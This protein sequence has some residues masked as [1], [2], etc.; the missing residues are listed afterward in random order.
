MR[1]LSLDRSKAMDERERIDKHR[2]TPEQMLAR[3]R[4]DERRQRGRLRVFLGAAPGVGKTYAMLEEGQRLRDEG[5]DVVIGFVETYR[6]RET[7]AQI[8]DLEI[9]PRRT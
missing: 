1:C 3:V 2:P 4:R 6:R 7:E 9:V 8:G 5:S